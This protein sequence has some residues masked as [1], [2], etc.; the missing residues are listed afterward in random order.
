MK[1]IVILLGVTLLVA[2]TGGTSYFA[3]KVSTPP[4]LEQVNVSQVMAEEQVEDNSQSVNEETSNETETQAETQTNEE[5]ENHKPEV[6]K[7]IPKTEKTSKPD[8]KTTTTKIEQQPETPKKN[9]NNSGNS[10]NSSKGQTEITKESTTFYDS[11][12]HGEKEFSSESVA[13]ARGN[14]IVNKELDY[15]LDWNEEHLDNQIK[16]DINYFRVYPSVID[17]NG[18]TWYYLHFFCLSGEGNDTKLKNMY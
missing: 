14:E 15:V 6:T 8:S 2:L 5:K 3:K 7:E 18:K 12:T 11:I 13:V 1:K 17:E 16:P 9:D 4:E 10:N